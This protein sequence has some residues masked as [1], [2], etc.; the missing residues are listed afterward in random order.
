MLPLVTLTFV[1]IFDKSGI[2]F[3]FS[4]VFSLI[5]TTFVLFAEVKVFNSTDKVQK[6]SK[7]NIKMRIQVKIVR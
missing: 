5:F 2:I 6:L 4:K 1:T 3:W 7:N